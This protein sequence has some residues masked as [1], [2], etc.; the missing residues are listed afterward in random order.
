MNTQGKLTTARPAQ[1]M[2]SISRMVSTQDMVTSSRSI[3]ESLTMIRPP[4]VAI[5]RVTVALVVK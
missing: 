4:S 3:P 2:K 5:T 1:N